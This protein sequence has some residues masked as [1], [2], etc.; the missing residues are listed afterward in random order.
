MKPLGGPEVEARNNLRGPISG[1]SG[2]RPRGSVRIACRE[3]SS[4][5]SLVPSC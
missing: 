1:G 3:S 5:F 4:G 2:R